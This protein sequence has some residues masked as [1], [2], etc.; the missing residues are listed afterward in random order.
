MMMLA[1]VVAGDDMNDTHAVLPS[2]EC[3]RRRQPPS[4]VPNISARLFEHS[5]MRL[6]AHIWVDLSV[7]R[8]VRAA[9]V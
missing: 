8:P 6:C 4:D 3:R 1:L 2:R 7:Y 9:F 5:R